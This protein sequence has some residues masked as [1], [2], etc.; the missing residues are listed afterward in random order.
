MTIQTRSNSQ[1]LWTEK[2]GIVITIALFRTP[3]CGRTIKAF[4]ELQTER[5]QLEEQIGQSQDMRE[6]IEQ[7]LSNLKVQEERESKAFENMKSPL[8]TVESEHSSLRMVINVS[9]PELES[10]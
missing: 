5:V 8:V 1:D 9:K 10:S 7:R 6:M 3:N 4:K 2:W